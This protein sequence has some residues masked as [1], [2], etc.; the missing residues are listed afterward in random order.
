MEQSGHVEEAMLY[1]LFMMSDGEVSY[2][3]EKLFNKICSEL[4]LMGDE[5]EKIISKCCEIATKPEEVRD[6]V[7][8]DRFGEIIEWKID[9]G[10]SS[11]TA[12]II[13]NLVNL[14][15]ADKLY[16]EEEKSIVSYLIQRWNVDKEVFREM[17][18]TADTM[19]ALEGQK[20]WIIKTFSSSV[21]DK[22]EK[23]IDVAV[24]KLF[25]DMKISIDEL[26]M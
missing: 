22:R 17:I 16:S 12:R 9:T 24:E 25:N 3:E 8:G 21:R 15:Y 1:Y 4:E 10:N 20:E 2:S 7:R 6:F 23:T 13:W 5:K 26:T 19:L 18:D 14:G 11:N